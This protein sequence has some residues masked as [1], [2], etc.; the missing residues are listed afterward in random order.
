MTVDIFQS[1]QND[2]SFPIGLTLAIVLTAAIYLRGWLALRKTRPT[3]FNLDR[4]LSFLA[5]LA[6]L[7]IAIA[8]PLEALA[9]DLLSAHMIEHLIL[10]SLVPPLVLLGLPVVPLLRG[11]PRIVRVS[12]AGPLLRIRPLRS[13]LHQLVRMRF[14][15]LAMNVTFVLWHIPAAYDFALDHELWH[16]FEHLCFLSTSL[17]F[18]WCIVRPWP[19]APRK[20]NWG[21]LIYLVGADFVNSALSAFL[22]FCGRPVY[23]YYLAHPNQLQIDPLADQVLGAV[24][25][26][27]F[28]STAFLIPAALIAFALLQPRHAR[29][30]LPANPARF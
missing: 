5:G 28:G 16:D 9:D 29:R 6:C 3:Q 15:W 21:L 22:A 20:H 30:I 17:L 12:I 26:W 11:L 18:W 25:M 7:W 2:W 8:S 4:L 14:A 1:V 24:V 27:V 10:M 23:P 13:L 19:A